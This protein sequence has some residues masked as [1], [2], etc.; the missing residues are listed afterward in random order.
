MITLV[1]CTNI[2]LVGAAVRLLLGSILLL[3]GSLKLGYRSDLE[4]LSYALGFS[5]N[6]LLTAGLGV[7]PLIE[8]LLGAWLFLGQ[9]TTAALSVTLILFMS[10]T[11]MLFVLVRQGYTG[12][13]AC[14]G[15]VDRHQVGFIHLMRNVALILTTIF[16]LTQSFT[17]VCVGMAIWSLSPFVLLMAVVL[18]LVT[19]VVYALTTEVETFFKHVAS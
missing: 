1:G 16:V 7:I 12:S 18:L 19:V 15:A 14:F 8:M 10:F 11:V 2:E 17:S 9:W 5:S 4:L 3:A 13:C 6:R